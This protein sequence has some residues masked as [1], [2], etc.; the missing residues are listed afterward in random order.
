MTPVSSLDFN[1]F[2]ESTMDP[3]PIHNEIE[4]PIFD[5]QHIELNQ[6]HTFESP[7]D[8]LASS[9]FYEIELNEKCDLDSQICDP[10]HLSKSILTPVLL[11]NLNNI[12]ESVLIPSPIIPE[13]ESPKLGHIPLLENTC[14][15]DFQFLDLDPIPEPISTPEPLLDLSHFPE[16]VLVPVFPKFKSIILSFHTSFWDKAVDKIDSEINYGI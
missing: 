11:P 1:L 8:K 2:P 15:L 13:L 16:S 10:V 7:I 3:V 14:G 6:F 4:L 9:Q 12:L 5:D